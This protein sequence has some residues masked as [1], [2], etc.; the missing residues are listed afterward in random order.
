MLDR[1]S[2]GPNWLDDTI[3][4]SS[5]MN[6]LDPKVFDIPTA[7]RNTPQL[8]TMNDEFLDTE[9]RMSSIFPSS[10]PITSDNSSQIQRISSG[11]R[12]TLQR[13]Q[14]LKDCV[15]F[16]IVIG[17]MTSYPKM[18]IQGDLLPPFINPPC[19]SR[20][21]LAPECA[22]AGYHRC[23]PEDLAICTSFVRMYYEKTAANAQ[24]VWKSI[25]AESARLFASFPKLE[26][27]RQLA[28]LQA[29]VVYLLLQAEDV[30][31]AETNN[32]AQL[33]AMLVQMS[34]AMSNT[35]IWSGEISRHR[36]DRSD[37]VYSES[38]SRIMVLLGCLDLVLEGIRPAS[39]NCQAVKCGGMCAFPLPCHRDLW[40]ARSNRAWR[41]AYDRYMASRKGAKI[42]T[43]AELLHYN[44]IGMLNDT[45]L[46]Q[47]ITDDV[48]DIARW[49]EGLDAL[50]T[51][52]WMCLPFQSSPQ[53]AHA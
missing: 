32:A 19:F 9:S 25:Y 47:S 11:P 53:T 10:L 34:M 33:L 22:D 7:D 14:M 5:P 46:S 20:E 38:L 45:Q 43:A 12:G 41:A 52:V 1:T 24:H 18:M 31:S 35:I 8:M 51:L 2:T 36:P 50:G 23:L 40:L 42:L 48:A 17:Q 15:L 30:A 21:D 26:S 4:L 13:R 16:S 37:W 27:T 39:N 6:L 44:S 3:D 29:M 28:A 49:A